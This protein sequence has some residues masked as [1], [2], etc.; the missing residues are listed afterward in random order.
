MARQVYVVGPGVAQQRIETVGGLDID[1]R[2]AV[3][4]E[5]TRHRQEFGVSGA[6]V[7]VKAAV[8][9]LEQPRNH[10]IFKILRV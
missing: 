1:A 9:R 4:V 6:D 5:M 3:I 8:V 10:D 2:P 7:D